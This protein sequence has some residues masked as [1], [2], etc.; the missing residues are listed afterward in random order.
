M[1][2]LLPALLMATAIVLSIPL[3]A[4]FAWLMDGKYRPPRVLK[5]FENVLDTGPQDWKQY[6]IALHHLQR[7]AVRVRLRRPLAAAADAAEPA[8]PRHAGADDDLQHGHIVY[9]QHEFAA[10][11]GRPALLQFQPDLLHSAEHVPLRLGGLLRAGGDHPRVS[12]RGDGRQLLRRH[13]AGLHVHLSARRADLRRHL[14]AAGHADDLQQRRGRD[15]AGAR[16]DGP[17]RQG[18]SQ[19]ANDHRRAGRGRHS[20]QDAG[21]QR[22]RLLRHELRAPA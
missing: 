6:T 1:L 8:R 12:R 21:H 9:D 19:A 16:L 18:R 14:H 13:V 11:F 7:R 10:L 15:D 3:S 17:G 5:W 4:Y 2:W 22:R 20:D